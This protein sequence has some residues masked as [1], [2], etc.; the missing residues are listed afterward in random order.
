M[1]KYMLIEVVDRVITTTPFTNLEKA[2]ELLSEKYEEASRKYTLDVFGK[3]IS[4]S[5]MVAWVDTDEIQCDYK[6]IEIK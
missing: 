6:I 3:Y 1:K 4:P 5:K 2:K